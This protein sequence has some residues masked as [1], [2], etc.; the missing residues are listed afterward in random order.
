MPK[1]PSLK[2][3][4]RELYKG[5]KE[6]FVLEDKIK[7]EYSGNGGLIIV[8]NKK[9]GNYEHEHARTTKESYFKTWDFYNHGS[10]HII[11][12]Y[13]GLKWKFVDEISNDISLFRK[14][15]LNECKHIINGRG[16]KEYLR[17]FGEEALPGILG[18]IIIR[19]DRL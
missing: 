10:F 11:N 7:K 5:L 2:Y 8:K 4:L 1:N 6:R 17:D 19:E 13:C 18:M 12:A 15:R 9:N 3:I 14:N 16:Y